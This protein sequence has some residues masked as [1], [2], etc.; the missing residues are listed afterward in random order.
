M[1]LISMNLE[2]RAIIIEKRQLAADFRKAPTNRTHR[3]FLGC[4]QSGVYGLDRHGLPKL[5]QTEVIN[6]TCNYIRDSL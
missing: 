3:Y 1:I 5:Y 4:K 6:F 2:G